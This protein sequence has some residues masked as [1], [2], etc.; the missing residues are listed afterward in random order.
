MISCNEHD[1]IEIACL[2]KY[3][4]EITLKSGAIITGHA[5]DTARDSQGEECIKI[6]S[7]KNKVLIVLDLIAGLKI[8]IDNPHF[9]E[10][11]FG[12]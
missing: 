5:L 11:S 10:V 8:T 9:N 2:F 6:E 12:S 7:D 4:I 3:P 1:Y